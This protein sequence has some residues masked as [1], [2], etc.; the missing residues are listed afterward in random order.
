MPMATLS[1]SK[2]WKPSELR[3][4][5]LRLIEAGLGD[6]LTEFMNDL[7]D[8]GK[9]VIDSGDL[10]RIIIQRERV[11]RLLRAVAPIR[12][13]LAGVA[14]GHL[15]ALSHSLDRARIERLGDLHAARR[16][17]F[18]DGARAAV[19][20]YVRDRDRV[21]PRELRDALGLDPAQVSRALTALVADGAVER[22]DP[23]QGG[24]RRAHWYRARRND[25]VAPE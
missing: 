10:E 12:S 17:A 9:A 19:L 16:A 1:A 20:Q 15:E 3:A 18:G 23:P 13:Q 4:E 14:V 8:R 22:V 25:A 24:D 21:R 5:M 11:G 7:G 2:L 6:E